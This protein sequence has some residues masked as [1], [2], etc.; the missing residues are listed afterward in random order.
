MAECLTLANN[1]VAQTQTSESSIEEIAQQISVMNDLNMMIAIAA[2]QQSHVSSEITNKVHLISQS[3]ESTSD[4]AQDNMQTSYEVAQL[5]Q[6]LK[7]I[8]DSVSVRDL[9]T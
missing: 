7:D 9:K 8:I 4:H 6:H 1:G 5:T 2:E 3:A